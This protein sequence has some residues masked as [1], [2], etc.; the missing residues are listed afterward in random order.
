MTKLNTIYKCLAA[1]CLALTAALSGCDTIYE[2]SDCVSS[3]NL[4][5]F[6]YDYN[7][8]RADAFGSEV[9]RITMF[10]FDEETGLLVRR[11]EVDKSELQNGQTLQLDIDPGEYDALVWAG[12][13]EQSFDIDPGFVGVSGALDFHCRLKREEWSDGSAHV[14]SDLAPVF[15]GMKHLSLPYSSPSAPHT[16]SISLVK[17]TNVVR[18]VLQ[19]LSGEQVNHE[20]FEFTITDGNG[21]LNHDNSL[22]DPAPITYHPWRTVTGIVDINT[23]P[24]DA[25]SGGAVPTTFPETASSRAV[26]GASLAEFT[27]NRLLDT[28]NPRLRVTNRRT[29]STVLEVGVRDYALLVKGFYHEAMSDQEYLDRQDEYNMTFFIDENRSWISNIIIINNWRIVRSNVGLH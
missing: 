13:H 7:M 9:E 8:K 25:P 5:H 18:V 26:L 23:N 3:Y 19:S 12:Y 4:I 10:L 16:D 20:D 29:G 22:R 6:K 2:E 11:V 21:W 17:N 24:A 28:N 15:H 14:T 1:G 27:V